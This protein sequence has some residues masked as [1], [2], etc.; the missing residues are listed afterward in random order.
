MC[1]PVTQERY[2]GPKCAGRLEVGQV[3]EIASLGNLRVGEVTA[4]W[5]LKIDVFS[6]TFLEFRKSKL[7]LIVRG[8][9]SA[10]W[11]AAVN[12]KTRATE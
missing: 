12:F 2:G 6:A 3:L 5:G 4:I 8:I 10:I 9:F 1:L 11:G 7:C